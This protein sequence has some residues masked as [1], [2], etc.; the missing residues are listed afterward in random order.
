M[1][2]DHKE[3]LVYRLILA[4]DWARALAAGIVAPSAHDARD[5]FIHLSTRAQLEGTARRYFAGRTDLLALEMRA[6]GLGDLRFEPSRHGERFPHLYGDL[7][8]DAVLRALPVSMHDDS[9]AIGEAP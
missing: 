3:E 5:G 7:N 8:A 9:F 2:A 1:N 6:S 4:D